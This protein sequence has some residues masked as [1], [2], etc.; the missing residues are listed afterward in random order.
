M[1]EER[2]IYTRVLKRILEHRA[3]ALLNYQLQLRDAVETVK[4]LEG[5]IK[6]TKKD[7]A[8]AE[9]ILG[10]DGDE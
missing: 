1:D 9:E 3:G 10:T 7:I 5:L 4:H 2:T 6:T 8:E